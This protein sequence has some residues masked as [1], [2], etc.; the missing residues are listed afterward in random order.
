MLVWWL[1]VLVTVAGLGA[2]A[3]AYGSQEAPMSVVRV[4]GDGPDL[5][6]ETYEG[7][8]LQGADNAWWVSHDGGSTWSKAEP[9]RS[10]GT[11]TR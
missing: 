2:G 11:S 9:P 1:V 4:V 6:A 8:F 3:I 5:W 7:V 10:C